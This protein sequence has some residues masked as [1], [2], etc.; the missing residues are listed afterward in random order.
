MYLCPLPST[1]TRPTVCHTSDPFSFHGSQDVAGDSG[2]SQRPAAPRA[3]QEAPAARPAQQGPAPGPAQTQCRTLSWQLPVSVSPPV[4]HSLPFP[5]PLSLSSTPLH[6]RDDIVVI[7]PG[8]CLFSRHAPPPALDCRP[9]CI[10]FLFFSSASALLYFLHLVR[11]RWISV[12]FRA[13]ATSTGT[14]LRSSIRT[15]TTTRTTTDEEKKKKKTRQP[16]SDNPSRDSISTARRPPALDDPTVC[17][18]PPS[19]CATHHNARVQHRH[20]PLFASRPSP[21]FFVLVC[22]VRGVDD[23]TTGIKSKSSLFASPRPR[24]A[25]LLPAVRVP[26]A[27]CLPASSRAPHLFF[28]CRRQFPNHLPSFHLLSPPRILPHQ[29]SLGPRPS[30]PRRPSLLLLDAPL[31]EPPDPR[32]HHDPI[33][34]RSTYMDSPWG[35]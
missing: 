29:P 15:T 27:A 31:D 28:P 33:R 30:R 21:F 11:L 6:C 35:P 20:W 18:V 9:F 7:W 24:A 13:R 1:P 25:C 12:L 14:W 32:R 19:R 23:N 2:S 10:R 5:R 8:C 3:N 34:N 17:L 26:L 4:P 22:S 16:T